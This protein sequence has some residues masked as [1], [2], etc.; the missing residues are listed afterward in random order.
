MFFNRIKLQNMN[1]I[2]ASFVM[3]TL[4]TSAF[5]QSNTNSPYSQFGLGDL[6]DQS[7]SFNKGMNG[8]GLAMRRG[9]EVNPMNPASYSAIDS[10]TMLFDAGLSGQITNYNE[11]GTKL[12]GKSGG[13]DYVVGLFRAF[14]NVGV[15]FGVLPYS[16]IGYKYYSTETLNDVQTAISTTNEGNGGLHQLFI[17][18]GIRPI[19]PLSI[20]VNLSYL[21]G[22]YNR[23]VAS[24]SSSSVNTLTKQYSADISSYKLD[25]GAQLEL[26]VSKNDNFTLAVTWTPGHS[27]KADAFLATTS[28]NLSTSIS[29]SDTAIINNALSI[30]TAF[31]F[32][33]AY[34]H[35]QN[36]RVGADLQIQKW[37]SIDYPEYTNGTYALKS[38]L[39]KDS[40][41]FNLGAEW[42]PRPLGRKFLQRVRYRAGVGMATPYYYINGKEGPKEISASL[43]FGIPI[44]NGYN[45]RS[46]LSISGQFVHRSADNMIKENMFR[47][48][49]GFTFNERWFA[50]WK[51]E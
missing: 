5:A 42:T 49:I 39:L 20:G 51:V 4:T 31:G 37:G 17:G 22:E 7:V 44:M 11:N 21:W 46:I 9:N 12:N 35:A 3:A 34:N 27:L 40:Y 47:L 14:K 41:R 10:L 32:G 48:N 25:F 24:S 43:G 8:V 28:T 23:S 26:P 30:P 6:T 29:Q 1:K 19:K 50:K 33:L 13:F 36:L 16:N 15:S 18:T 45:A 38:G 2:L